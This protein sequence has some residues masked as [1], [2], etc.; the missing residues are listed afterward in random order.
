MRC[1]KG[2]ATHRHRQE[3][4]SEREKMQKI[5]EKA[6]DHPILKGFTPFASV[7]TRTKSS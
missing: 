4:K 5:V 1:E 2:E 7:G 3:R 6:K